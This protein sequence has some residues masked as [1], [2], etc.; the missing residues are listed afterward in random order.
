MKDLCSVNILYSNELGFHIIDTTE[1]KIFGGDASKINMRRLNSSTIS[2]IV[3][4]LEIPITYS[5]YYN[6]INDDKFYDNMAKYGSSGKRL[7]ENIQLLMNDKYRFIGLLYAFM[8]TYR[9]YA[10]KEA[11]TLEDVKE[12][13]KVLKK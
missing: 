4:Y 7:Q 1:W 6:K 11:K 10:S 5:K 3:E 8:D 12:L 2:A 9:E 13:V